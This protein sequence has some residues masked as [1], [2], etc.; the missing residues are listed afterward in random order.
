MN[1]ACRSTIVHALAISTLALLLAAGCAT[2][3]DETVRTT[4]ALPSVPATGGDRDGDADIAEQ[5]S[6]P[7]SPAR[8]ETALERRD[9][10]AAPAERPIERD[11][12]SLDE[13]DIYIDDSIARREALAA[14]ALP[15]VQEV[16]SPRV[17]RPA[18]LS[19]ADTP[20]T[21][22][23]PVADEGGVAASDRQ[24]TREAAAPG[25]P[26]VTLLAE[27]VLRESGDASAALDAGSNDRAATDAKPA[28][29]P[30]RP[31]ETRAAETSAVDRSQPPPTP[32]QG[33]ARPRPVEPAEPAEPA[34]VAASGP[35]WNARSVRVGADGEIGVVLPGSGWLYVGREYGDGEVTLLGKRGVGDD[36]AFR[37]RVAGPGSYGLWFQQQDSQ[38]GRLV[39]ERL[40]VEA[41]PGM[42]DASIRVA[43]LAVDGHDAD[44]A[45]GAVRS[46]E[47]AGSAAPAEAGPD[48]VR[49]AASEEQEGTAPS[50][51]Q[52]IAALLAADD[53]AGALRAYADAGD[54]RRAI[55][56]ALD[57]DALDA[58]AKAITPDTPVP[59]VR[60]FWRD[61]ASSGSQLAPRA[62]RELYELAL[63]SGAAGDALRA[64]ERLEAAG[65]A[66]VAD[67][68][69]AASLFESD[70]QREDSLALYARA[71]A[72]AREGSAA[73][74]TVMTLGDDRLFELARFLE[75]VGPERD[76]R[77]AARL[78]RVIVDERPLSAHW[79]ASR[80]RLEH[81]RR[82][83]FEVR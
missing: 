11:V 57:G 8:P 52:R 34:A 51:E 36:D 55:I 83:Y 14:G 69:R 59:V 20:A 68:L 26:S 32:S 27:P 39:N 23:T 30:P 13:P 78:Y 56:D 49:A 60:A 76:L 25:R 64:V 67:V 38:T 53:T 63:A 50:G 41:V 71:L 40:S 24:P 43:D 15:G 19:A 3:P 74:Q 7:A 12:P 37:F 42:A 66:S 18:E 58:L 72:G 45:A 2:A 70:E 10:P 4:S 29:T 73:E 22:Q 6:A 62:R 33:S 31:A 21:A 77:A 44:D 61:V 80:S 48:T 54:R 75:A 17:P 28:E 82:H 16:A 35:T 79:E 1:R 5:S 65:E 47:P 9:P 46:G 81:L